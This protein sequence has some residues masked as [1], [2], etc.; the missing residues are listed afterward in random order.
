M[1][2]YS[3]FKSLPYLDSVGFDEAISS[4]IDIFLICDSG[5]GIILP[6]MTL[7]KWRLFSSLDKTLTVKRFFS[8]LLASFVF[9][10]KSSGGKLVGIFFGEDN[11]TK[12]NL[13]S[14]FNTTPRNGRLFLSSVDIRTSESIF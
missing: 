6:T 13:F 10:F 14:T 2:K 4:S 5:T 7:H 1:A 8:I 11:G 3:L 12:N 9:F